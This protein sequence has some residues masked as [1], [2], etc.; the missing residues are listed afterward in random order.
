VR[1]RR[2]HAR[3]G[4]LVPDQDTADGTKIALKKRPSS[5]KGGKERLNWPEGVRENISTG[6][7]NRNNFL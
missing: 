3:A 6:V 2:K 7:E 4:H 5:L 1:K